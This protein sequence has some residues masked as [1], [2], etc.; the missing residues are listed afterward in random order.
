VL[1]KQTLSL[2]L[3]NLAAHLLDLRGTQSK[4]EQD[5]KNKEGPRRD[6]LTE[7]DPKTVERKAQETRVDI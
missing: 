6:Q 3:H 4:K 1:L 7:Q 5:R 2:L